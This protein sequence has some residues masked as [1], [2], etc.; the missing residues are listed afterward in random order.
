ME[1]FKF[2]SKLIQ[3]KLK[4]DIKYSHLYDFYFLALADGP[5]NFFG[6]HLLG[7]VTKSVLSYYKRTDLISR[8]EASSTYF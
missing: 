5:P 2:F 6:S 1:L 7:S 3:L 8:L 4:I